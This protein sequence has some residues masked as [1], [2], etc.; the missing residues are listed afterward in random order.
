MDIQLTIA[1]YFIYGLAFYTMG[2]SSM[3]QYYRQSNFLFRKSLYFLSWF[4]IIHG[5]TEWLIMFNRSLI[6]DHLQITLFFSIMFLYGA[7][8]FALM[9]FAFYLLDENGRNLRKFHLFTTGL[10]VIWIMSILFLLGQASPD[11]VSIQDELRLITRYL[12]ALPAGFLT[13]VALIRYNKKVIESGLTRL[14]TLLNVLA[15]TF[16]FYTI[17]TGLIGEKFPFFPANIINSENF[18]KYF[19][20]PIEIFRIISAIIIALVMFAIIAD[21]ELESDAKRQR[22]YTASI[23]A[24]ER[25]RM[26]SQLHDVALQKLF[27]MGMTIDSIMRHDS[28]NKD[29][30]L[31]VKETTRQIMDDIRQ[32]LRSDIIRYVDIDD[33]HA[34]LSLL[35]EPF[36][37]QIENLNFNFNIP[38]IF[39]G[40]I[41]SAQLQD[42]VFIVREFAINTIKHAKATSL[43]IDISSNKEMILID[44]RDNGI[45]FDVT[46]INQKDH[47]GIIGI[48]SRVSRCKG[49]VTFSQLKKGTVCKVK[50]PWSGGQ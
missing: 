32:F 34:E 24:I 11:F 47:F 16:F 48:K 9:Y 3:F 43:T 37:Q 42:I 18:L 40:N 31:D 8:F 27:S 1:L 17:F 49:T 7:S 14:A 30:L 2:I 6:F 21:F 12:T 26:G 19:S 45:G 50:I 39:S 35:L 28:Q 22:E 44:M 10:S 33:F 23:R 15:T 4:G 25:K 29:Q 41:D 38:L 5:I 46:D 20:I 13:V 36:F